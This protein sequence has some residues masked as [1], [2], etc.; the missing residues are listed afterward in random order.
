MLARASGAARRFDPTVRIR[1]RADG[2]AVTFSL[3]DQVGPDEEELTVDGI[4]LVVQRGVDGV[5]DAGE[6]D[7]LELRRV[8]GSASGPG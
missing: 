1:L 4:A 5:V 7:R 3:A 8:S 6:H 2:D